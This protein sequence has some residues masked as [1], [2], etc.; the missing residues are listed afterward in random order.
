MR[1]D[2]GRSDASARYEDVRRRPVR[3]SAE[4][5]P[6]ARIHGA[7]RVHP[8]TPGALEARGSPDVHGFGALAEPPERAPRGEVEREE[9]AAIDTTPYD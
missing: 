1:F 7:S 9:T 3:A 2:S 4:R 6:R 5:A 8:R